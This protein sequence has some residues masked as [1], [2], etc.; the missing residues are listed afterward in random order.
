MQKTLLHELKNYSEHQ[1]YIKYKILVNKNGTVYDQKNKRTFQSL[2][3]WANNR[4]DNSQN[5]DSIVP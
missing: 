5:Y 4:L 1:F 3:Q 2:L